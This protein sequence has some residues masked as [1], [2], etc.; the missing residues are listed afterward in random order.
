M[1]W[2]VFRCASMADCLGTRSNGGNRCGPLYPTSM[3]SLSAV[4]AAVATLQAK[5]ALFIHSVFQA[6]YFATNAF[7][8]NCKLACC[9]VFVEPRM[10]AKSPTLRSMLSLY[11]LYRYA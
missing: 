7:F 9:Q 11:I 4:G 5:N 1:H 6:N 10:P 3:T 2:S 8:C